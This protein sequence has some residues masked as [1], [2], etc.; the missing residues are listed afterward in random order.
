MTYRISG[1][2]YDR[3]IYTH[4]Q[5]SVYECV[6]KDTEISI[7]LKNDFLNLFLKNFQLYS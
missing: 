5:K 4:K 7:W 1:L 6:D 2:P 3:T